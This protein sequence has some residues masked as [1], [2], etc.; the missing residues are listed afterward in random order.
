MGLILAAL[1]VV[2][3]GVEYGTGHGGLYVLTRSVAFAFCLLSVVIILR[4]VLFGRVVDANRI[5]GAVCI[6]LLLGLNWAFVYS[7]LYA[8]DT[9]AF[10][11]VTDDVDQIFM[12][13]IYYSFVTLTTLGYGDISPQTPAGQT[14]SAL[15]M[16][17]GYGIIAVPTGIVTAEI[18]EAATA[19]REKPVTTRSCPSCTQEGHDLDAT[20]CKYC[21]ESLSVEEEA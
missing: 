8:L 7:F 10:L 3:A 15:I 9:D 1:S 14:I 11:G 13:L 4:E 19:A 17:L 20:F 6:Y 12:D 18:V 5:A 21:G 2:F 16:I